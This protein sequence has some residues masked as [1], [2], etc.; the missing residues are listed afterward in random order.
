MSHQLL[1]ACAVLGIKLIHASPR[2]ATTKGK[3][4]RF[5]RTVRGQFLVELECREVADLSELNGLFGAWV[6]SVYHHRAHTET[7]QAPLARFKAAGPPALPEPGLLREAFLWQEARVV[8]KTATVSLFGNS[9]EVDASSTTRSIR[10]P[11][12]DWQRLVP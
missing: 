8:T 6:E 1:R 11:P 12:T 2:A 3:I 4:E 10:R 9:Y 7:G 5:F